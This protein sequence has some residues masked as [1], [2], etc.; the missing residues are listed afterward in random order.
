MIWKWH[1]MAR[2][3][4]T[5]STLFT[6]FLMIFFSLDLFVYGL[7]PKSYLY[8]FSI[9]LDLLLSF[10]FLLTMLKVFFDL[11][12]H[13][14]LVT[15][16]TAGIS[17]KQILTLP[18]MFAIALSSLCMANGQWLLCRT[19]GETKAKKVY[20]HVLS[21]SDSSRLVYRK[22]NAKK[23][24]M[25]DA[26]WIKNENE[27]WHIENMNVK[28]FECQMIDQMVKNNEGILEKKETWEN[29][30][31][32]VAFSAKKLPPIEQRSLTALLSDSFENPF[33]R[34]H[35][36]YKIAQYLF[37]L[38]IFF[39]LTPFLVQKTS[40]FKIISLSL[41]GFVSFKLL[42]DGLLILGENQVLAPVLAIWGLPGIL[43]LL[44][45]P[46]CLRIQ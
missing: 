2:M 5:F 21:L 7:R 29:R 25:T 41:F 32:P 22:Y 37:P 9:H 40:Y 14:E 33:I 3:A 43:I 38:F 42:L 45:V 1:I 18:F 28:S 15:L 16:Q 30:I 13:S 36:Y 6:S 10:C 34:A 35:F 8:L 44:F 19:H 20:V 27:I 12:K 24:E 17:K 4:K 46:R 23:K 39:I 11:Q 31:F 26:F